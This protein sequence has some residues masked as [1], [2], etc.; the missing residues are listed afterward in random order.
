ML[1]ITME[2]Q[3]EEKREHEME[4]GRLHGFYAVVYKGNGTE[5]GN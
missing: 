3:M 1:P 4:A 2:D 5:N